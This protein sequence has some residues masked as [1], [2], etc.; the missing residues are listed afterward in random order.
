V[1]EDRAIVFI[2]HHKKEQGFGKK[3]GSQSVRGSSD[4][5]AALDCHISVERH[6]DYLTIYQNKLRVQPQLEPFNVKI[7]KSED[8]KIAFLYDGTDKSR[9][10]QVAAVGDEILA[11]LKLATEPLSTKVIKDSMDETSDRLVRAALDML[12]TSQEIQMERRGHGAHFYSIA[13]DKSEGED[14]QLQKTE[15]ELRQDEIL[16]QIP[17]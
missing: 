3:G 2:H 11:M 10:Q 7:V 12:T 8:Q 13:S 6:E 5:F 9:E 15:A 17:F 4:I 14:E 1:S 16:S